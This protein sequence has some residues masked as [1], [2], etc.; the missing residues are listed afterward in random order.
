MKVSG[1][2]RDGTVIP[3][4]GGLSASFATGLG[5]VVA[6][7]GVVLHLWIATR[8]ALWAWAITA[9]NVATIY[10]L[11]RE[12][13]AG[14]NARL[15]LAGDDIDID[16]GSRLRCRFPRSLL[17]TAEAATWRTVPDDFAPAWANTAK[18]LE[19]NVVLTLREPLSARLAL[20]IRKSISRI[21]LRV[22]DAPALTAA[23]ADASPEHRPGVDQAD[24][25]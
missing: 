10:W 25:A 13:R 21:G 3:L 1:E 9:L 4:Q 19:P 2:A 17:A 8:S 22:A 20:G 5:L 23:L 6:I 18:P 15:T 24:R 7:E 12:Y 16:A 11:W 14:S